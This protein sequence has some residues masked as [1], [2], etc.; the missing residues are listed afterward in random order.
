MLHSAYYLGDVYETQTRLLG[1]VAQE[2]PGSLLLRSAVQ[3]R[4]KIPADPNAY[5]R[6]SYGVLG[7]A[8]SKVYEPRI[9][10]DTFRTGLLDNAGILIWE[11]QPTR[12]SAGEY[13]AF[14]ARMVG[15][16]PPLL[17]LVIVPEFDKKNEQY[18]TITK[19]TA[20]RPDKSSIGQV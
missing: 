14:Q 19:D 9:Y 4:V 6:L 1:R 3:V 11:F 16:S 17:D 15:L 2:G 7:Q 10:L 20:Q 12:F 13:V 5:W 18:L 8:G